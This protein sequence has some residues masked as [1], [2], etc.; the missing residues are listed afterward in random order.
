M[1]HP[2]RTLLLF[3]LLSCV[4]AG[5]QEK[6]KITPDIA[7]KTPAMQMTKPL[8]N[9]TGWQDGQSYIES[10]KKE[11]DEKPS[12]VIV[13][14]KTGKEM[15]EKKPDVSW[16]DYRSLADSSIDLTK[17]LQSTKGNTRH[18]YAKDNDL[19]LLDVV[20]KDFKRLTNSP[21][22]EK[23]PTFS[24]DGNMIAYTR[25]GNLLAIDLATGQEK[26]ITNDGGE[27]VYNGYAAWVYYE[28]IF[29]RASRY[30]A[31]WWSPNS[32]QIA[33]YRFDE[34]NVPMFPIYNSK[35]P[36]TPRSE[37]RTPW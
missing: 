17:P 9:I 37:I 22:E 31:Y 27:V 25:D 29:G 1:T 4:T 36:I 34:A 6:K 10:K 16:K 5:A 30:K 24:P 20:K 18:I 15:G 12:Q 28:E 8:P 13:D 11:G 2:F 19:Y 23:N 14:A 35:R 33:F 7:Y 32:K 21:S 26:Q 3:V